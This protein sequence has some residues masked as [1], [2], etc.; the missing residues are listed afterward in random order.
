MK[1]DKQPTY[2]FRVE[3]FLRLRDDFVRTR[4]VVEAL[5]V[6]YNPVNAALFH[7]KKHRTVDAIEVEGTLWWMYTP[8]S[9][10]RT[11]HVE[12]RTPEDHPRKVR[13][14]RGKKLGLSP[15]TAVLPQAHVEE[16]N[17]LFDETLEAG[18]PRGQG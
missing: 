14:S 10:T 9:D 11:K 16:V 15:D 18:K 7:L 17:R 8:E 12:E 2:V 1:A 3:E 13:K 5:K 6:S 4:D